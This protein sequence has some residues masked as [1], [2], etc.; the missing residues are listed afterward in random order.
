MSIEEIKE[1]NGDGDGL[2]IQVFDKSIFGQD[3]I[4]SISKNI[5]KDFKTK[6]KKVVGNFSSI[7]SGE[8]V[9]AYG[10]L[11]NNLKIA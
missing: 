4:E 2:F 9:I 1:L 3:S 10:Y 8:Y 7:I 11:L 5:Q 6:Y